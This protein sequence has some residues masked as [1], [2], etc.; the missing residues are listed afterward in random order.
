MLRKTVAVTGLLAGFAMLAPTMASAT[1]NPATG[2]R[3][4][5]SVDADTA[6]PGGEFAVRGHC[7]GHEGHYTATA[8]LKLVKQH[9]DGWTELPHQV[10]VTATYRVLDT[11]P[12]GKQTVTLHCGAEKVSDSLL[13][14]IDHKPAPVKPK[15]AKPAKQVSKVPAGA[16]Q[17]GGGGTTR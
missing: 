15:P 9:F 2:E 14:V 6:A 13:V 12:A 16:P 4:E 1:E 8:G 17:T 7:P 11:T 10:N 3:P 5:I